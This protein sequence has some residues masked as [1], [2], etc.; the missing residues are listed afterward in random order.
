M[1]ADQFLMRILLIM[2][3]AALGLVGCAQNPKEVSKNY[4]SDVKYNTANCQAM[5]RKALDYNDRVL[6]RMG[7]GLALGVFLGPFGI[8]LVAAGD[9]A[10]NN[11]R[12]AWSREVHL[13]CSSEPLPEAL[14]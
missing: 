6:G 9:I 5:R 3:I 1:G 4:T 12:K 14:K 8:P 10:Q 2:A 7:T 11:E 13:A